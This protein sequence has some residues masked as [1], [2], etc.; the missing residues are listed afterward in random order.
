MSPISDKLIAALHAVD[1]HR[2]RNV[3]VDAAVPTKHPAHAVLA[4][5]GGL[6]LK[7]FYGDYEV[8]EV[9]FQYLPG[10]DDLPRLWEAALGTEL[11]GIAEYH[12]AHGELYISGLG[13]VF[14]NSIIHPAFWYVGNTFQ[15]AMEH[16]VEGHPGRPMLLDS[17]TSAM[18]YGREY[19]R[20][21]AEVLHQSSPEIQ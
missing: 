20:D 16:I 15:E 17:E 10:K 3:A 13:K 18:H 14:G 4:E 19:T 11:I 7:R 9:D 1:W 2:G 8:C 6:R 21:D 5:F 12:N